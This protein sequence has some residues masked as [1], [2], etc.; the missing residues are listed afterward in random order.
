MAHKP[1]FPESGFIYGQALKQAGRWEFGDM[2]EI[3]LVISDRVP[4]IPEPKPLSE[5]YWDWR[6]FCPFK[7]APVPAFSL[8]RPTLFYEEP[9]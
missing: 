9:P 3:C 6:L 1:F 5:Q 4:R 2:T 8:N 7:R